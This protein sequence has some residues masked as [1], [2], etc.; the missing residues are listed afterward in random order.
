MI[1]GI[2]LAAG[3]ATR[4]GGNKLM[5]EIQG[6][7]MGVLA[8]RNMRT[9]LK[10]VVAVIHPGDE[11]LRAALLAE[12]IEVVVCD[13]AD[14]GMGASLACGV[15]AA[16]DASGWVIALGDMPYIQ[17]DTMFDVAEQVAQGAVIVAPEYSGTRGHPVGFIKQF[18]PEL[19]ASRGD[20]GARDLLKRYTSLIVRIQ[21]HDRGI[22]RD[23]DTAEDLMTI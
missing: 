14:E 2:L 7:P 16:K 10:H 11:R 18:G 13:N 8:A 20:T 15:R 5:H 3:Y 17:P 12:N 1:T 19:M 21:T 22:L 4:F 6:V 23:I 9:A